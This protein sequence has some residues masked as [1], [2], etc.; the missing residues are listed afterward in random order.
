MDLKSPEK[1]AIVFSMQKRDF[2]GE[3]DTTLVIYMIIYI[4][5]TYTDMLN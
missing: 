2:N 3:N 1:T 4:S 5:F